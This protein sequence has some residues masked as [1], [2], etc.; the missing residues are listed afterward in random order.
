META[1]RRN[2]R[3]GTGAGTGVPGQKLRRHFQPFV[4]QV[5]VGRN[6]QFL[7]EQFTQVIVAEGQGMKIGIQFIGAV[8]IIGDDVVF[9]LR[10][11]GSQHGSGPVGG[12]IADDQV[13]VDEQQAGRF[14]PVGVEM[15]G[16]CTESIQQEMVGI[17]GDDQGG[18]KGK[19]RGHHVD[20]DILETAESA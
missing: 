3:D 15:E 5:P 18:G 6:A 8:R 11:D 2:V 16:G 12:K 19:S 4:H 9:N 17:I 13:A 10:H 1:K 14:L 20:M 7:L